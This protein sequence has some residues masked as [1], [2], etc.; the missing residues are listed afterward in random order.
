MGERNCD[1]WRKMVMAAIWQGKVKARFAGT[2]IWD[3]DKQSPRPLV[4]TELKYLVR[5]L[6]YREG[7]GMRPKPQPPNSAVPAFVWLH[8]DE[9]ELGPKVFFIAMDGLCEAE[10]RI[11]AY[12]SRDA[13]SA[14][15][16]TIMGR[17]PTMPL[18]AAW[19]G[20][21]EAAAMPPEGQEKPEPAI[22]EPRQTEINRWLRDTWDAEGR[23]EGAA[24]FLKLRAYKWKPGSPIREWWQAGKVAGIEYET[25]VGARKALKR[26]RIQNKVCEFKQT[27][28]PDKP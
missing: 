13:E 9:D 21:D 7:H 17:V 22:R 18:L 12:L 28:A 10:M 23:P 5:W 11:D 27:A 6:K 20:Q 16:G 4:A 15:L 25:S 26:K 24:F 8:R 14:W 19:L 2:A 1:D 3:M